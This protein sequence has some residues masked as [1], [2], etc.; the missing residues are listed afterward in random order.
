MKLAQKVVLYFIR[1]KIKVYRII[2]SNKAARYAFTLFC[3]PFYRV[4]KKMPMVFEQSK[5]LHFLYDGYVVK[6]FTYGAVSDKKI[7]IIHGWESS[8]YRFEQYIKPLA[9]MGIQ[10][11]CFDAVAHGQSE[12][13][14]LNV[15]EYAKLIAYINYKYGAFTHFMAHS[16]GAAALCI[17]LSHFKPIANTQA[18]KIVFFAPAINIE[19]FFATFYK[20]LKVPKTVQ[21]KMNKLVLKRSGFP[22][23]WFNVNAHLQQL[24]SS[25]LWFH[26]THDDSCLFEFVDDIMKTGYTN[27]QFQISTG[28][29]HSGVYKDNNNRKRTLAFYNKS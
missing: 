9:D 28:L 14:Q 19:Y 13:K 12:G 6:G 22:I 27:I 20:K 7:L 21:I 15:Y 4:T 5:K 23:K 24:Q 2:S 25:I 17:S 11:F 16:L 3:T 29:G 26:D 1:G 18:L 8:C 10:V